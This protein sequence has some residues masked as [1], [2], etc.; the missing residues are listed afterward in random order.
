RHDR[1]ES[2][3]LGGER[4]GAR[5]PG[6]PEGPPGA[7]AGRPDRQGARDVKQRPAVCIRIE[8][9]LVA[10]ATGEADAAAARRVT[11]HVAACGS[12]GEEYAHYRAVDRA[13]GALREVPVDA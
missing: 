4:A 1:A 5:V 13:I 11:D 2:R 7:R 3:V 8:A 9:D 10:A 6:A 12:C